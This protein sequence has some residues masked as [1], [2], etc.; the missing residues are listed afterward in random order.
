MLLSEDVPGFVHA[1]LHST[2]STIAWSGGPLSGGMV[3]VVVRRTR[4]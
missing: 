3:M 4:F 1:A 2:V